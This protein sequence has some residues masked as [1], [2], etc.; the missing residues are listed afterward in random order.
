VLQPGAQKRHP[1]NIDGTPVLLRNLLKQDA[2][3]RFAGAGFEPRLNCG[4]ISLALNL[5]TWFKS[6]QKHKKSR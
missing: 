4:G 1:Q 2:K 3:S 6:C 5:P